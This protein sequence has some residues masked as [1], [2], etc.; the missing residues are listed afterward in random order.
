VGFR[1]AERR[2]TSGPTAE[3]LPSCKICGGATSACGEKPGRVVARCFR[4]SRCDVCNFISVVNPCLDFSML[5]NDD[6]Y[7]GNGADDTVDYL[8]ELERPEATIRQYEWRGIQRV[9]EHLQGDMNG[10]R[11]LDYGSGNGALVR[12]LRLQNIDAVGFDEGGLFSLARAKGIPILT[13]AELE[14]E[15][16]RCSVITMIEVIEHL[17]DPMPV[18]RNLRRFLKPGGLLFLTT[19]NSAPHGQRFLDWPYV[20]PDVH[21]SY[22][23][24][25]NMQIALTASGFASTFPGHVPGWD[26]IIRFKVLK[27]LHWRQVGML[28]KLIPWSLAGR[29]IDSRTRSSDHPVGRAV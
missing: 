16:G 25:H 23:D 13:E 6:Y 7:R 20:L 22:F 11:W 9:V 3:R 14:H 24:P 18:L 4:F 1:A 8:F 15:V 12:Y 10:G 28:E 27:A 5:Y 17:P 29:F 21:V 2:L 26:D 19:G